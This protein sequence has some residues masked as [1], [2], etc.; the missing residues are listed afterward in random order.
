MSPETRISVPQKSIENSSD[1]ASSVAF[2]K[3][4]K[5]KQAGFAVAASLSFL[6]SS[7]HDA[8]AAPGHSS[9]TAAAEG[10]KCWEV[11][12]STADSDS[13]YTQLMNQTSHS[14][15]LDLQE[16]TTSGSMDGLVGVSDVI[17]LDCNTAVEENSA[18]TANTQVS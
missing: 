18:T 5:L 1:R 9:T 4:S 10:P 8:S 7:A 11:F 13:F 12:G 6:F 3:K 17:F 2:S 14:S 16:N 15:I